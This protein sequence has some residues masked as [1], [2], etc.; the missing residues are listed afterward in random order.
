MS[1]AREY[2]AADARQGSLPDATRAYRH[3]QHAYRHTQ[4]HPSREDH[5]KFEFVFPVRIRAASY[6]DAMEVADR[7]TDAI[8]SIVPEWHYGERQRA[9]G[10]DDDQIDAPDAMDFSRSD[11]GLDD[12]SR[13]DI[14]RWN[15]RQTLDWLT[16]A[17]PEVE[18]GDGAAG[19]L[20]EL[21]DLLD[22]PRDR[23]RFAADIR[24]AA[25][26]LA[27]PHAHVRDQLLELATP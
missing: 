25:E 12:E 10:L 16:A 9:A 6:E 24:A 26:Q 11:Y 22:D 20:R 5:M 2:T 23:E 19:A 15:V 8:E 7:I 17:N 21:E 27:P 3:T 18:Y 4:H 1:T 14:V 13:A